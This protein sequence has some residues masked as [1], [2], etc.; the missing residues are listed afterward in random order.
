[1]IPLTPSSPPSVP[2]PPSLRFSLPV[3]PSPSSLP[4]PLPPIATPTATATVTA[5]VIH[6][7]LS[8]PPPLQPLPRYC[9]Y[10]PPPRRDACPCPSPDTTACVGPISSAYPV[11]RRPVQSVVG[12]SRAV[13][14]DDGPTSWPVGTAGPRSP[15]QD[16]G[17][18]WVVNPNTSLPVTTGRTGQLAR[19]ERLMGFL[20]RAGAG[21][22][23]RLWSGWF[24]F[25]FLCGGLT[26]CNRSSVRIGVPWCLPGL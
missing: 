17:V 22:K 8:L 3:C 18:L 6:S 1:M 13:G 4:L 5:S 16:S 12:L 9:R 19:G 14:S 25:W 7:C 10:R 24:L 26:E 23:S 21:S 20:S 2:L 15:D 11:P